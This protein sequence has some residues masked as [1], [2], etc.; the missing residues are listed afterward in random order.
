MRASCIGHDKR[1]SPQT[2]R[3]PLDSCVAKPHDSKRNRCYGRTT[4]HP[5]GCHG[6]PL[7]WHHQTFGIL[8]GSF[9]PGGG[10]A[11]TR[12]RRRRP[13]NVDGVLPERVSTTI[14]RAR[15]WVDARTTGAAAPSRCARNQF[16]TPSW[17]TGSPGTRPGNRNSGSGVG[18]VIADAVPV[19]EELC[20]H[21]VAARAQN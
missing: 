4:C 16:A 2:Q 6:R 14:R 12:R 20:G 13:E 17:T 7:E 3:V 15:S 1:A 10:G 8:K 9:V 19:R 5:L 18:L 21:H 11:A